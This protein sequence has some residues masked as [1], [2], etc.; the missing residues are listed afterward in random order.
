GA[1]TATDSVIAP[2][3]YEMDSRD[4]ENSSESGLSNSANVMKNDDAKKSPTL[5]ATTT[6]HPWYG[7]LSSF[8]SCAPPVPSPRARYGPEHRRSEERLARRIPNDLLYLR[9][10]CLNTIAAGSSHQ[11]FDADLAPGS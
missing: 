9:G 4:H 11:T 5:E 10:R 6:Q 3:A 1:D 8:T 2:N 7:R